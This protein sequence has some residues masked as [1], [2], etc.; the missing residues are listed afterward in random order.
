M[1]IAI[2]NVNFTQNSSL[3]ILSGFGQSSVPSNNYLLV[4]NSSL[5]VFFKKNYNQ[6]LELLSAEMFV[7]E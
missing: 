1:G 6:S 2:I 3:Q 7:L 4:F 5:V